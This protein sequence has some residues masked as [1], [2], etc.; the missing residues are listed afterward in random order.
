MVVLGSTDGEVFNVL[1]VVS[2]RKTGKPLINFS[3]S[4]ESR[5]RFVKVIAKNQI[6]PEGFTGA[7]NPAWIFVDEAIVH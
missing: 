1:Q 6:I 7:G 3:F 2:K 4:F 5:V